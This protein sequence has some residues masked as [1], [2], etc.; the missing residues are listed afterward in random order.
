[1]QFIPQ[2]EN[3]CVATSYAQ[4][5]LIPEEALPILHAYTMDVSP[6]V[7]DKTPRYI[8]DRIN[9]RYKALIRMLGGHRLAYSTAKLVT[10]TRKMTGSTG[11]SSLRTGRGVCVFQTEHGCLHQVTFEN[12]YILNPEGD[13]VPVTVNRFLARHHLWDLISVTKLPDDEGSN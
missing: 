6:M 4:L 1:M 5:G 9:L 10:E 3:N 12:G 8:C 11:I 7:H 2:L 13:G